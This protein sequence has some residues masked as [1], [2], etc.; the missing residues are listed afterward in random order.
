MKTACKTFFTHVHLK[1]IKIDRK[2]NARESVTVT[3]Q[4]QHNYMYC[5]FLWP[6]MRTFFLVTNR[7]FNHGNVSFDYRIKDKAGGK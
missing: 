6:S 2:M 7:A 3:K 5:L 4:H 1:L